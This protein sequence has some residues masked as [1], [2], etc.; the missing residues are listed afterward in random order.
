MTVDC[1][2]GHFE[3]GGHKIGEIANHVLEAGDWAAVETKYGLLRSEAVYATWMAARLLKVAGLQ[4]WAGELDHLFVNPP[5]N[6]GQ[7]L[8]VVRL[9]R[10]P[11]TAEPQLFA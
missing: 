7:V 5:E 8:S 10:E 6:L 3:V 9:P 4:T 2:P 1:R 11:A